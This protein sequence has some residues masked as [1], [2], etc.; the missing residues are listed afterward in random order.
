MTDWREIITA[1]RY[2][3]VYQCRI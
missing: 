2:C 3:V 1:A